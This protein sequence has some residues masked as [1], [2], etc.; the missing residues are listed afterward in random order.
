MRA[1]S[2]DTSKSPV[3]LSDTEMIRWAPRNSYLTMVVTKDRNSGTRL[4]TLPPTPISSVCC[5]YRT[6][7]V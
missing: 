1:L 5:D 2:Q 7:Y 4:W 3:Q 6:M